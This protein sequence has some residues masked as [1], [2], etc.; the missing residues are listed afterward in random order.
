MGL[1]DGLDCRERNREGLV[2]ML[3]TK[4]F[5]GMREVAVADPDGHIITFAERYQE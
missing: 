3:M 4:Q 2:I 1:V 5:Y